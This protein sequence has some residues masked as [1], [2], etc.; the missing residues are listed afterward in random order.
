MFLNS[1]LPINQ[2]NSSNRN[3]LSLTQRNIVI[4]GVDLTIKFN[5]CAEAGF[6][7]TVREAMNKELVFTILQSF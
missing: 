6:A 5:L 7:A 2:H 1:K 4:E 3:I